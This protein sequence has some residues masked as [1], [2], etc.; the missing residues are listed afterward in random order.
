MWSICGIHDQ[1]LISLCPTHDCNGIIKT[2]FHLIKLPPLVWVVLSCM[3][4]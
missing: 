3:R 1:V 2:Y 4:L